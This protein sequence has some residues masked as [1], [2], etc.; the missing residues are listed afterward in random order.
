M[1]TPA[2]SSDVLIVGGGPAGSSCAWRLRQHGVDVQILDRATFPRDKVCAGWITPQV[3]ELLK[4]DLDQYRMGRVLQ[5]INSFR[6]GV[7]N[8]ADLGSN[9]SAK[10]QRQTLESTG[11]I[12]IDYEQPVSYGIRRCEFDEYLLRR[13]DAPLQEGIGIHAIERDRGEW[14]INGQFRSRL[15]IGAGGHFCPV[16]R[17][18]RSK[19]EVSFDQPVVVAQE[20]EFELSDSDADECQIDPGVP[21]LFF[22]PDMKG[23]AWCFRKGNW[24]NI[25]LG[26][27]GEP[28]LSQWRDHFVEWLVDTGRIAKAIDVPFKGHAY[29]LNTTT[30]QAV[31]GE[32]ILLIGD[33]AGL[34]DCHSGEGIRPAIESALFAADTIAEGRNVAD[35]AE[36]YAA[37]MQQHF[38]SKTAGL[39]AFIP[40]VV[41]TWLAR[42]MLRNK[43]FVRGVVLDNWFLNRSKASAA[44][45]RSGT[46]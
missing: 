42:H 39:P 7:L 15:L 1:I 45:L 21:E 10:R 30:P 17:H 26:R 16:A 9:R 23:Y 31:A 20:A 35:A 44:E 40:S 5:P 43:R 6:V 18:L 11:T 38:S 46:S 4:L 24:L 27:E 41:Q 33:S 14:L 12:R 37:R 2:N 3:V 28:Y 32:G 29:R 8:E 19:C 13:C 36:S 25:G 34:A 22:H